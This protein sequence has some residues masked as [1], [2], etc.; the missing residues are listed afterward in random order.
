MA[1]DVAHPAGHHL[2]T[3]GSVERTGPSCGCSMLSIRGRGR[4]KIAACSAGPSAKVDTI[5]W[6]GCRPA[7][8]ASS[9]R[10][11]VFRSLAEGA[12]TARQQME[13]A[14]TAGDLAPK[15]NG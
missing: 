9:P 15:V 4:L 6:A 14:L 8:I 10:T 2:F 1:D 13:E 12:D 7:P 5:C 3:N 11:T